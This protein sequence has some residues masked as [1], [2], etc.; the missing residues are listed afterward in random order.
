MATDV[1]KPLTQVELRELENAVSRAL[2]SK[3]T[4]HELADW[5]QVGDLF[6]TY[7]ERVV[8]ELKGHR[9]LLARNEALRGRND[10]LR[11][12][13]SRMATV[14]QSGSAEQRKATLLEAA[15]TINLPMP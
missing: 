1:P 7:A 11:N 9:D 13:L 4:L 3:D 5:R 15:E 12:M 6:A 10:V 14:M 2:R 8:A